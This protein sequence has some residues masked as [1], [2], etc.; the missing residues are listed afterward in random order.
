VLGAHGRR[1]RLHFHPT[2]TSSC[3]AHTARA[4][5]PRPGHQGVD[6]HRIARA[7]N[8]A[9]KTVRNNVSTI[10]SEIGVTRRAQAVVRARA[11]HMHVKTPIR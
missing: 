2:D 5:G 7:L 6:N 1:P 11:C 4:T 8:L 3:P 10:F 9:D